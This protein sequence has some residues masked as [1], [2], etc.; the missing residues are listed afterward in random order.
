MKYFWISVLI[1]ANVC[2][3][4]TQ[5]KKAITHEDLWMMK[6]VGNP[7]ISPNGEWV[8]FGVTDPNYDEKE[9]S[10]DIY[11]Q[12]T[13]SNTKP[14]KLTSGKASE[15]GYKWS[16]DGS[17]IAFQAKRDADEKSQIYILNVKD[18]G[19]AQ[20]LTNLST[21]ASGPQWSPDGSKILF[22]SSVF[23]MCYADSLSKKRN[24]EEKKIKYKA[25]VYNSFPIRDW[26]HWREE[27]QNHFYIQ[28]VDSTQAKNIF[29]EIAISKLNNFVPIAASW[30]PDGKSI[31]FIASNDENETAYQE[32][33]SHIYKVSADGGDALQLTSG[34]YN[35]NN[36]KFSLNGKYLFCLRNENNQKVY[37]LSA[38]LRY[39]FPSLKNETKLISKKDRP[40]QNYCVGDE[41]IYAS[42]ENAGRDEIYTIQYE[43]DQIKKIS[44]GE[45]GCFTNVC[46]SKGKNPVIISNFE[47]ASMPPEVAIVSSNELKYLSEFNKEKLSKLDL[48]DVE[49]FYTVSSKN[50]NIRSIL[51][52]PANF[53]SGK[54][55]PLFILIHGG[56][57]GTWKENWSYR[58]NY[59]LLAQAGYI[60]L[61]SDYTGSTGYGE[62]FSQDIQYDPFKGPA[63]EILECAAHAIK[64]YSFIDEKRQ[65]AGGASYGG[66]LANW[67][68]GTTSHFK[69][70]VSHAGL[71][72]SVSQWGTSDVIY[73][74]ELMNGSPPW[75]SNK[76]WEEQN[77]YSLAPNFKTPMLITVGELDYRVPINNSI[78]NF[79]I[80]QRLKIPSKLIVF[81][82]EN[83]WILK[84]ENSKFFYQEL[85]AWLAKYLE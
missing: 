76:T 61:A 22:S 6:R 35:Y 78:E 17:K 60:I 59:H 43:N 1:C 63:E 3:G 79:Y 64:K 16:P 11:I 36:V 80:H 68:Q 69:C 46:C 83:H 54:K 8:I 37:N 31:L 66:H 32:S 30:S 23:P 39:D 44:F 56:P 73:G 25:K 77:P 5:D 85:L 34:N 14:R 84:A 21:G 2:F 24:E 33:T 12:S 81:P 51:I 71:V 18:G 28:H 42:I 65:A 19:E 41:Y 45:K 57:A 75:I 50:K 48:T 82:E 38:L 13:K 7:E 4:L 47:T 26:D 27:K 58:W 67:L 49:T 20:R 72:N 74:R 53:D 10:Q 9:E 29:S 15:N 52:K 70:L 40:I 55:Y 62:K